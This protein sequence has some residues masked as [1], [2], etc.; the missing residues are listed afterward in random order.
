MRAPRLSRRQPKIHTIFAKILSRLG[1]IDGM[2]T[3]LPTGS[4]N[5]SSWSIVTEEMV[6]GQHRVDERKRAEQVRVPQ[7]NGTDRDRRG[8]CADAQ[9]CSNSVISK[10]KNSCNGRRR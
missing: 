4:S 5:N 10:T 2:A 3:R 8:S 7:M 1:E 9:V 6:G